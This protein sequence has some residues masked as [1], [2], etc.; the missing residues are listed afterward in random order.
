MLVL[1]LI[2]AGRP[3]LSWDEATTADVA[4]RSPSDIW[5]LIQNIDAVVGA[6]YFFM[7][8]WVRLAGATELDLRL[9]AIVAMAATVAAAG[10]LGRRLFDPVVGTVTGIFLCVLPNTSRYAAEARPY[11]FACL[12]SV[13]AL[14]ALAAALERG[15]PLRWTG[16]GLAVL[17]L[18]LGHLVALATLGAHAAMVAVHVHRERS[19]RAAAVWGA[20]LATV[21][22]VLAP[23]AV[24]GVRQQDTQLAWVDPVTMARLAASPGDIAGSSR[25]AWLLVGLA[26]LA[27][28]RPVS[29][30]APVALLAIAPVTVV[31]VVS[32]FFSPM[33][34]PRYLLVVLVPLA[35]LAAVTVVGQLRA[36][37]P[38]GGGGS[39]GSE[40]A[41]GGPAGGGPAGSES[42]GGRPAGSESAGGGP[43][44]GG[45]VGGPGG[46]LR[47]GG[48]VGGGSGGPRRWARLRG[49][50]LPVL[51]LAVVLVVLAGTA[52]PGHRSI[53][54][55]TAKNGPDYRSIAGIIQ[56]HQLPG[57]AMVFE[58]RSRA[59]R[60][61]M[62]YY[63]RRQ[64]SLPRD[65]LQRRP[66]ADAGW[67]MADEHP[68][69][70]ARLTGVRR[71]WL[72]VSGPRQDPATGCPA[73]RPV[74]RER[75]ERI[76][77]W[78]VSRGTVG[79]YRY[80]G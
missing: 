61:G 20:T 63:L 29:A 60:A 80:R 57:D 36:D 24:L 58:T 78:Q 45:W 64:P 72:L 76:G 1:G 8:G 59:M 53:R 34:V 17:L 67:L 23:L 44:S 12:M 50:G 15:R 69:A 77:I 35:M 19:W 66:A 47:G 73:L 75:Y 5:H 4:R 42:A 46:G 26:L 70:A 16:Y 28:W 13:L 3:A 55:P 68:D 54:G 56:Q 74:L 37:S 14:L 33:W 9:P 41:G 49:W 22:G 7:H 21:L 31:A 62:E 39:G 11:A 30:M 6:Y 43:D 18:G 65:L 40:S 48:S 51:R 38:S 27:H 71:V 2:G 52:Y 25:T 32:V 10:E 79:L